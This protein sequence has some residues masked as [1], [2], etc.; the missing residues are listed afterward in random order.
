MRSRPAQTLPGLCLAI[1]G[2]LAIAPGKTHAD[3]G[4]SQVG[5]TLSDELDELWIRLLGRYERPDPDGPMLQRF[6]T[7]LYRRYELDIAVPQFPM[8]TEAA[9]LQQRHGARFWVQSLSEFDLANRL[10]L[11]TEAPT[12]RDGYIGLRYDR[13]E[14][15]LT[16]RH[17]FRFDVGHR[18]FADAGLDLAMRFHPRREKDDVDVE[19]FASLQREGLGVAALRIGALDPFINASFGLVEARGRVLDEH[20][21]QLDL[22]LAVAIDLQTTNIAGLQG[23]L[24]GGAILPQRR[25]HRFPASPE[26]DHLRRRHALLGAGLIQWQLPWAAAVVGGSLLFVDGHMGWEYLATPAMDREI[27][28]RT[29][30]TRLYTLIRPHET[31]QIEGQARFTARPEWNTFTTTQETSTRQDHQRLLSL[32]TWWSPTDVIGAELG[33]WRMSRATDGPPLLRLDGTFNRLTTRLTLT[34]SEQVWLAFGVGWTLDENTAVYDGGGMT[35][36]Y[37]PVLNESP[38]SPVEKYKQVL[39]R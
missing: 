16:D 32:R 21:R 35:F 10:Q 13:L 29:V 27:N 5:F 9:W 2:L 11:K 6:D 12:W 28:E 7:D 23:E 37:L 39:P 30:V 36:M 26:Q 25:R 31:L 17:L 38:R 24:H 1:I 3:D 15:R 22:P 14:D 19:L 4:T 20:V 34:L 33:L 18:N 8:H